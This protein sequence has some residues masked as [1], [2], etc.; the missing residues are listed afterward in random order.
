L[1]IS[2]GFRVIQKVRNGDEK[3]SMTDRIKKAFI[4]T[5]IWVYQ[6][7]RSATT[8]RKIVTDFLNTLAESH[9]VVISTQVLNEFFVVA[10]RKLGVDSRDAKIMV[11]GLQD[12]DVV[13]IDT[14]HI[15]AAMDLGTLTRIS[16]WDALMVVAAGAA[17]CEVLVSEDLTHDRV[18]DGVRVVN[19]FTSGG[20][21]KR[22]KAN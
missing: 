21:G 10:T 16:H 4:D 17:G 8:K 3:I 7:D 19:P 1:I 5:N 12:A 2:V 9:K 13:V 14:Q 15:D 11:Q 6:V 20:G 22:K 18:I